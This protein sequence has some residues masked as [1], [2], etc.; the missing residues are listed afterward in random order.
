MMK[1]KVCNLVRVG[2]KEHVQAINY[3]KLDKT[4]SENNKQAKK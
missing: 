3:Q 2:L 1:N 4:D